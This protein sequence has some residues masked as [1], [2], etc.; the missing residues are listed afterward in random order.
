VETWGVK[1][2]SEAVVSHDGEAPFCVGT[3]LP[4]LMCYTDEAGGGF[5]VFEN[6]GAPL[7]PLFDVS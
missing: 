4:S 2:E 5:G 1:R 7:P 6:F 3:V